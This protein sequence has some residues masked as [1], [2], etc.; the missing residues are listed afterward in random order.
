MESLIIK[1]IKALRLFL[2]LTRTDFAEA[3]GVSLSLV[4]L[5]ESAERPPSAAFVALVCQAFHI[6]PDTIYAVDL[7]A[8]A[9]ESAREESEKAAQAG[10]PASGG[11]ADE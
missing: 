7:T 8:R 2:G 11:G 1:N 5:V 9:A 6:R 3:V 10:N 4:S